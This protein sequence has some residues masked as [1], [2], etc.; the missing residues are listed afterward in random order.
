MTTP[1]EKKHARELI[2]DLIDGNRGHDIFRGQPGTGLPLL[3]KALR[4][5][6]KTPFPLEALKSFRRECW[7]CGYRATGDL[8]DLAVAQHYGLATNLLDWTTNPLV[9]PFFVS[10]GELVTRPV[11]TDFKQALLEILYTLG[12]SFPM[13]T[14]CAPESIGKQRT[15]SRGISPRIRRSDHL[16]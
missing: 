13:R 4:K 12:T 14:A 1:E 5:E 2:D 3:P 6:F 11:L 7:G 16:P 9:A 10:R 8:E 15:G